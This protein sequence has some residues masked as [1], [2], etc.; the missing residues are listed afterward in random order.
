MKPILTVRWPQE[1]NRRLVVYLGSPV[2]F[3]FLVFLSIF[4]LGCQSI[5]QIPASGSVAGYRFEGTVDLEEARAFLEG[6]ALP[7]D[8]EKARHE[9]RTRQQAPRRKE[10]Q[11]WSERYSPD[12]GAL[13]FLEAMAALPS[14]QKV[15]AL[16]EEELA[17][18]SGSLSDTVYTEDFHVLFA[19]G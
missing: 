11:E 16:Y 12:V 10:L 8:L 13:L 2:H 3:L 5:P 7:A 19:P 1:Q 15:R 6:D 14:V 9:L 17:Y 18:E 4:I